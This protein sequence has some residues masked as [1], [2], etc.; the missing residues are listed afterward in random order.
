MSQETNENGLNYE[1]T[2]QDSIE[3]AFS[4]LISEYFGEENNTQNVNTKLNNNLNTNFVQNQAQANNVTNND[5][6]TQNDKIQ[7]NLENV[8]NNN[9]SILYNNLEN[10]NGL[11]L[12]GEI[13][14]NANPVGY[15]ED[16]S[17]W[18]API[19]NT[20]KEK[21]TTGI[22]YNENGV[23][24]NNNTNDQTI[25]QNAYGVI[26]VNGD[27]LKKVNSNGII[28]NNIENVN[29]DTIENTDFKLTQGNLPAKIGFWTKVRNFFISDSKISYS[30][31]QAENQNTGLWNKV[32]N[33]FAFG[34]NK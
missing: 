22:G 25:A 17:Y 21:T 13:D 1:N 23:T 33:F 20:V 5:G 9:N 4:D 19:Y 3:N 8:T 12:N 6:T 26:T 18:D 28:D 16:S 27:V 14:Y 31:E 10:V 11:N 34:K 32:Q 15:G 24:Q 29:A 2:I 30:V 7:V